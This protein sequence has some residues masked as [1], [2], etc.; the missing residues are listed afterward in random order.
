[1]TDRRVGSHALD[2]FDGQPLTFAALTDVGRVREQ[3][4]DAC[5]VRT[6]SE[7]TLPVDAVLVAADGVG[8]H[9]GGAVASRFVVDAVCDT[10]E[11]QPAIDDLPRFMEQ[12]LSSAHRELLREAAGRGMQSAM[13]STATVAVVDGARLVIAHV[14]DSRAYRLRDG[15]LEQ[16]TQDDSWVAEQARAGLL[17][18]EEIASNPQKNVLTQ[19]MGIG[20]SLNVHITREELR[21][22]DRYLLCSDGLHGEVND[23]GI[24]EI[25]RDYA[26]PEEAAQLLVDG[27][28]RAGGPD[29]ITAVIFDIGPVP[30][31]TRRA[32]AVPTTDDTQDVAEAVVDEAPD[33]AMASPQV[34]PLVGRPNATWVITAGL[35]ILIGGAAAGSWSTLRSQPAADVTSSAAVA[36]PGAQPAQATPPA[37]QQPAAAVAPAPDPGPPP[38]R[39][40]PRAVA[41]DSARTESPN[42]SATA[43]VDSTSVATDSVPTDSV[44]TDSVAVPDSSADGTTP[45][46]ASTLPDSAAADTTGSTAQPTGP[47]PGSPLHN[48]S[49][50]P[51]GPETSPG[52]FHQE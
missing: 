10:I 14:G 25:L 27:A 43:T 33:A 5:G 12:L 7:A 51:T 24:A 28:N 13:G 6:R 8:G 52:Q 46:P 9:V 35:A 1:M 44:P 31:A 16:L 42:D 15:V 39:R 36:G 21:A 23:A 11:D 41:T 4:E 20:E 45:E 18:E 2:P 26:Q 47:M 32:E 30:G 34:P 22:G 29:N 3:N 38:G 48:D 50:S 40:V 17:T 19:C 49:E 37:G